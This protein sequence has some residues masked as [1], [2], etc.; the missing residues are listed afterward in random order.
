VLWRSIRAKQIQPTLPKNL[1][2]EDV[3]MNR[4]KIQALTAA[5]LG[6]VL[7]A[8]TEA[9][10]AEVHFLQLT[11]PM[12][13]AGINLRS[14]VYNVQW[15]I[16]GDRATVTFSRKGRVVATVQGA[17]ATFD[18]SVRNDT[19]YFTKTPDG[20]L[21]INALGFA[22]TNKGILFPLVRSYLHPPRDTS[23]DKMLMEERRGNDGLVVPRVYK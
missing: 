18:R 5:M 23:V 4:M 12:V 14:A 8:N 11:R 20:F 16:Q 3:Q 9:R 15:D 1:R 22:D 17:C 6:V 13:V 21:A 2:W 10:S 19:L 7:A